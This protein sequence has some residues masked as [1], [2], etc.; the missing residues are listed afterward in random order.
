MP[1]FQRRFMRLMV[2]DSLSFV[3]FCQSHFGP[4]FQDADYTTLITRWK[5]AE[6]FKNVEK[7]F[8]RGEDWSAGLRHG[9]F[10]DRC[11]TMPCRRPAFRFMDSRLDFWLRIGTMN[12]LYVA[13]GTK[14]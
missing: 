14:G 12:R 6:S 7:S 3:M 1:F 10:Q 5:R 11:G 13:Y 9:G 4:C 8:C 2:L